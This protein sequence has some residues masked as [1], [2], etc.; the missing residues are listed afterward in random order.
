MPV[1]ADMRFL[2]LAIA[3]TLAVN[4]E[5]P[6]GPVSSEDEFLVVTASALI[7][8]QAVEKAVGE[9]PR[10]D[11]VVIDIKIAPRADNKVTLNLDDFTLISRKDGQRSHPLA[12]SQ[13]AGTNALVVAQG[14][15]GGVGGGIGRMNSG[16]GPIWGGVPGTGDRPR[17]IGGDDEG[18]V[19][20]AAAPS[21]AQASVTK[22]ASKE[23]ANPLMDALKEKA[24]PLRETSE[25]VT[26]LLY[27]FLEGKHKLKD[28]ELMYQSPAGRMMLD[29]QK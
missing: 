1:E 20:G 3:F 8:K 21:E 18:A 2:L 11:L 15:G 16:R 25:P 23:K 5:K 14:G 27:F 22:D 17:R 19:T 9:D 7:D 6:L 10:M 13:I 24:L 4:A 29:F 26:G 12:P 28:L